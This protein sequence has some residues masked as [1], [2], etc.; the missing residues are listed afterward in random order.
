M[1]YM[2]LE[3]LEGKTL[4]EVIESEKARAHAA[5]HARRRSCGSSSPP[6]R[7]SRSRI[8]KASPIAT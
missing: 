5:A 1:P 2:V 8:A 7:R 3:W 6:P 4:E